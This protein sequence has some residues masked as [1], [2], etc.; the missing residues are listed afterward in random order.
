[1][2]EA[3]NIWKPINDNHE[4]TSSLRFVKLKCAV[5]DY[6]ITPIRTE[7]EYKI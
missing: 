4:M 7:I 1:M 6:V 2:G 3:V 5:K